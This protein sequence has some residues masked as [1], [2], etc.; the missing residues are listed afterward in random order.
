MS[1][2]IERL[3]A[4][5]AD[6]ADQPLT[7]DVDDLLVRARRSVRKTRIATVST[8]VLTTGV[9]IAGVATWSANRTEST[10]RSGSSK[11]RPRLPPRHPSALVS[12][13]SARRAR[14]TKEASRS[15]DT[16]YRQISSTARQVTG[17]LPWRASTST[18]GN[19]GRLRPGGE[20]SDD[21]AAFGHRPGRREHP[22][23]R[24]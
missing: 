5:A 18:A 7:T 21:H 4:A 17:A 16:R 22:G 8:A 15:G 19:T 23:H 12:R 20:R 13:V 6:D 9:I 10:Q 24:G 14:S 1:T 2:D 11:A 3:L